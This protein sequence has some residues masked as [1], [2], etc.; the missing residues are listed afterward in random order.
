[1]KKTFAALIISFFTLI[2]CQSQ[3]RQDEGAAGKG[4]K[5]VSGSSSVR[6]TDASIGDASTLIPML[7]SDVAS[8][9]ISGLLI[10]GLI[11]YDKN[12]NIVGDL[13]E[14]WDIS[15]DRLSIT[16]HLR[17]GVLWEDGVE[18]TAEDVQF[19][20]NLITDPNTPTAYSGDYL[21][22]Q[23]FELIDKY[24][25]KVTYKRPFAPALGTW[26]NLVVLPKHIL[27]GQDITK[28]DYARHP[29]GLG[30]YRF[31][32]WKTGSHIVLKASDTYFDGKPNIDT[33]LFRIIP[34]QSTMFLELKSGGI[35]VMSLTPP[36][37]TRQTDS[38]FFKKNFN[39][40]RYTASQYTY[41]GY[42]L[43]RKPFDDVR[44]RQALSYGINKQELI[45]GVLLGL[46][47]VASTP[48]VPG[49]W[50]YNSNVKKYPH[51][52]AKAR[53]LLEEA[54]WK[55]SDGNGIVEKNG[56]E[57]HFT[58]LTNQGNSLRAKTAAIIQRRLKDIGV[59]MDIRIV[60]WAAFLKE[61]VHPGNFDAVIL[62]WTISPDPDQYDIWHSSKTG[63]SELNFIHYKNPEVDKLLSEGRQTFDKVKRKEIY[64]R[65][66][67][68]IAEEQPVTFLY[69]PDALPIVHK[70]FKGIDPGAAGIMYNFEKWYVEPPQITE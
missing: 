16:F 55:D 47:S 54:G 21:E 56:K 50:A 19:G 20:F 27:E 6:L 29:I 57:F 3:S 42:N 38:S 40:Y 33:Y 9:S 45:N 26:G 32:E 23:S 2:S 65:F 35:D 34:D 24:T 44:V 4:A 48:Y 41:L 17:K 5:E 37:F 70:R 46:G 49:T 68:I 39:K 64:D 61:F 22:V 11:K 10:N 69:V 15:D 7:A 60:E 36:Q 51:D 52:P 12:L 53:A 63:L 8:H 58:V 43:E 18:F 31:K 1:M 25:F 66:Q 28:T 14:S 30:P 62:G 59:K 13:A 67:E